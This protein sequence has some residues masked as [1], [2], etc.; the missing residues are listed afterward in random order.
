MGDVFQ[1]AEIAAKE[2]GCESG[3]PVGRA[4]QRGAAIGVSGKVMRP[5]NRMA[6]GQR[7]ASARWY[8]ESTRRYRTCYAPAGG[9]A[10]S[11]VC[12]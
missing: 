8:I 2:A 1:S 7:S 11:D 10:A 5:W 4:L 9:G 3:V 6:R 12:V